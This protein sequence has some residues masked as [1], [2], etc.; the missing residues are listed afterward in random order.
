MPIYS[1]ENCHFSQFS[2][3]RNYLT[4]TSKRNLKYP[5]KG[6]MDDNVK[7]PVTNKPAKL[8]RTY[9]SSKCVIWLE[10]KQ[11]YSKQIW[12][13]PSLTST[14]TKTHFPVYLFL[15]CNFFVK[16][17]FTVA[18]FEQLMLNSWKK[19][20]ALHDKNKYSNSCV[21]RKNLSERNKKP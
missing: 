20:R 7:V 9:G 13:I 14:V 21:I 5:L 19:F 12:K 16:Y 4:C 3:K 15:T 6:K 11:V 18:H 1:R 8:P 2:S 17:K 10:D